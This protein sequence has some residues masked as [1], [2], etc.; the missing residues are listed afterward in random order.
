MLEHTMSRSALFALAC[1]LCLGT[2]ALADERRQIDVPAGELIA[3]LK[4]LTQQSGV[5]VV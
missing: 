2:P 4:T 1:F 3:A 5:D